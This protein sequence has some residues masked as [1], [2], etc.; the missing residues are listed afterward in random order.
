M[1]LGAQITSSV[2]TM[3]RDRDIRK[4]T[5]LMEDE[6]ARKVAFET[7][8]KAHAKGIANDPHY[9]P[10]EGSDYMAYFSA[11]TQKAM[12]N[13]QTEQ[14]KQAN[15]ETMKKAMDQN[16]DNFFEMIKLGDSYV[17]N[18]TPLYDMATDKYMKAYEYF[19]DGNTVTREGDTLTFTNPNGEIVLQKKFTGPDTD[20]QMYEW[21]AS[22]VD[23]FVKPEDFAKLSINSR[24]RINEHNA[25]A[26]MHPTLVENG[27]GL[28]AYFVNGVD[29]NTGRPMPQWILRDG[30]VLDAAKAKEHG[31]LNREAQIAKTA[32]TQK[33]EEHKAKVETVE[34]QTE[35]RKT[36]AEKNKAMKDY[37]VRKMEQAGVPKDKTAKIL[38]EVNDRLIDMGVEP[39][40]DDY[41][42][43]RDYLVNEQTDAYNQIKKE[44]GQGVGGDTKKKLS[45]EEKLEEIRPASTAKGRTATAA[46]GTKYKSDGKTW[47]KVK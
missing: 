9:I 12:A 40:E 4:R 47:K 26:L 34:A 1:N 13:N 22:K 16:Y 43:I 25:R 21:A 45:P 44:T 35:Q 42:E 39:G 3:N 46:D 20:K 17:T 19:A 18:D 23:D 38:A 8:E 28:N 41:E 11:V 14:A 7:E 15:M 31:F 24:I 33:A 27:D 10:K 2:S 5:Q 32:Q 30:T 29:P 36:A 6:A 37:Y